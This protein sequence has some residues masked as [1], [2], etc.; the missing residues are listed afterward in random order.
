MDWSVFA[1]WAGARTIIAVVG[2]AAIFDHTR[3]EAI[4]IISGTN[5]LLRWLDWCLGAALMLSG[6]FGFAVSSL[7]CALAFIEF[8]RFLGPDPP[9]VIS[10]YAVDLV[11]VAVGLYLYWALR[12]GRGGEPVGKD[13]AVKR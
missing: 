9:A 12:G 2:F 3:R 4:Q 11:F 6:I 8:G 5:Q 7:L 1:F 13:A 10:S